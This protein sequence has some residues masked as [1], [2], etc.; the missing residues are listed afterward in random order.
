[1]IQIGK[2]AE[3]IAMSEEIDK[4]KLEEMIDL[5]NKD[6]I[7]EVLASGN[8][9]IINYLSV[10]GFIFLEKGKYDVAGKIFSRIV[11]LT[12][13]NALAWVGKGAVLGKLGRHEEEL[14]CYEEALSIDPQDA[15]T[16]YNKGVVLGNLGRHEEELSCYNEALRIDPE[17]ADAWANRGVAL[18]SLKRYEEALS[19]F[20][21][22]LR[23]DPKYAKAWYNKGAAL[24][25]LGRYEEAL[26]CYNE[27]L[28][29]DPEYVKAWYGRGV[30]LGNLGRHEEELSCY[31][32]ALRID[33][34]YADAWVNKGVVL[35]NLGRHEEALSCYNEALSIDPQD[36]KTW[37]NK[38]VTLGKLGRHK[39]EIFYYDKSLRIDPEYADAWYNK[40]VTLGNL[41]RHEEALPCYDAALRIDP[42]DAKTWYNKGVVLGNLGRYEEALSCYNEALRIDPKYAKT[43]YN[44]GVALGNLGRYEE[45]L[46]CYNEA[47]RIDPECAYTWANK[48]VAFS[49]LYQYEG[50]ITSLQKAKELFQKQK[51]KR[52]ADKTAALQLWTKAFQSWSK[53]DY[54]RAL[55]HFSEAVSLFRDL[56]LLDIAD[57]LESLSEI[58]P[59][60]QKFMNTLSSASLLELKEKISDLFVKTK[61]LSDSFK[62]KNVFSETQEILSAKA[63][64]FTALYKALH[65]E[66]EDSDSELLNTA[67]SVFEKLQF[68]T[69]VAAVNTLDN[70][71]R[72]IKKY[73][74]IEMIP[75]P[76]EKF[77]LRLLETLYVLDGVLTRKIP[78][79]EDIMS[80]RE[81]EDIIYHDIDDTRKEWTR[82]CIV[83]LDVNVEP[84]CSPD[85]GYVIKEKNQIKA[86]MIEA[87]NIASDLNVDIICFPELSTVKEWIDDISSYNIII[88]GG[89][90]YDDGFNICPVIINGAVYYIRKMNPSPQFET[91]VIQ[92]RKMKRGSKIF[93]FQTYCGVFTVLICMDY[94]R[95][96]HRIFNHPEKRMRNVDFVFVPQYNRDVTR[97]QKQGDL[98]CLHEESYPYIVQVNPVTVLEEQIGGTCII[99]TEHRGALE[100]Y[101]IE[102]LKPKDSIE[103]KLVETQ[104]ES[105]LIVDLDI[106]RK[107]IPVPASGP[108]MKAVRRYV[109]ENGTWN[110]I[111][112]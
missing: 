35:G 96:I 34:E 68:N 64:C 89:T 3:G 13:I 88:I 2:T 67:R 100:R 60:D 41:G 65:F 9:K 76:D 48:G 57:S 18:G 103:Y 23:I 6:R 78:M 52:D 51:S 20:D 99:G 54:K 86:K 22:T 81:E 106:K 77:L 42:L 109:F 50:A 19:C 12:S 8:G 72:V 44:K 14:S 97:F 26:S 110:D 82:I 1:L 94:I 43:W 53:E 27:A 4:K 83:Q 107:G 17:Y 59:L 75:E 45:A 102:R 24:G 66:F 85:F 62:E 32:E 79:P 101:V 29:I 10:I 49:L 90:Y 46:S 15:K 63:I 80:M 108:K 69:S 7:D 70:F 87:L 11:Q 31:N 25:S 112:F 55:T 33:P 92:G 105:M 104:K 47:L 39:E 91:E 37:V 73:E 16:W 84:L 95:E 71:T 40:G 56:Q 5:I 93:V 38:G 111:G 61:E 74:S 30:V 28:R 21:K 98:D 36:A 58:I